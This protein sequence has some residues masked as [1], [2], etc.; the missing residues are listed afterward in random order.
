[1][2]DKTGSSRDFFGELPI[3]DISE[4]RKHEMSM[5]HGRLRPPDWR[6]MRSSQGRYAGRRAGRT[7]P[8]S[9]TFLAASDG[10]VRWNAPDSFS[11]PELL[12]TESLSD[13][14]EENDPRPGETSEFLPVGAFRR[15][16][17]GGAVVR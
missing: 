1:M 4:C 17:K 11:N 16:P 5:M 8:P 13:V 6:D 12:I 10:I 9:S 2:A 7:E 15:V 3:Y 14:L